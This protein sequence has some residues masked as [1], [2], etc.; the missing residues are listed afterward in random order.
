MHRSGAAEG[1]QDILAR[2]LAARHGDQAQRLDHARADD[3]DDAVGRL[4]GFELQRLGD[5]SRNR[6]LG[7]RRDSR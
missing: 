3:L 5:M 4:D 1:D 7:R 2:I 6:A